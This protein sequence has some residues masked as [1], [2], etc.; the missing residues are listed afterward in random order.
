MSDKYKIRLEIDVIKEDRADYEPA[1]A[2][3]KRMEINAEKDALF[4]MNWAELVK[5]QLIEPALEAIV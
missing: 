1:Y 4:Y 3:T 2:F 5:S